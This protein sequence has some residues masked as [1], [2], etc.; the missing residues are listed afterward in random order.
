MNVEMCEMCRPD[1]RALREIEPGEI[2]IING[3]GLKS[4]ASG[5]ESRKSQCI[6]ELI[7]FSRPDS[8]VF[9]Q[10]V[11]LFRKRQGELL[12]KEFPIEA[13]VVMPFPIQAIT[14]LSAMPRHPVS[15]LRWGS[16]GTIMWGGPLSSHPRACAISG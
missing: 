14:L 16:S 6:F 13:D 10:N 7:Y 4:I 2:V 12:A 15:L 3:E 11:Y 5:I 1:T 9:G 8:E